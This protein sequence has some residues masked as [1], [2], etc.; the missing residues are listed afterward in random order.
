MIT[1]AVITKA[2]LA[3]I[4]GE[5]VFHTVEELREGVSRMLGVKVSLKSVRRALERN[6]HRVTY[7]NGSFSFTIEYEDKR[8]F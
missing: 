1:E 5:V 3:L 6:R 4:G 7:E 2:I 8:D